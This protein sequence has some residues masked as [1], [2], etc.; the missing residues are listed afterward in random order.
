MLPPIRLI[1]FLSE[2]G[3]TTKWSLLG[4]LFL[5]Y[6]GT[7]PA[8]TEKLVDTRE[9]VFCEAIGLKRFHASGIRP[10]GV[11]TAELVA[12]LEGGNETGS[13]GLGLFDFGVDLDLEEMGGW[14]GA[15]MHFGAFAIFGDDPTEDL[16]GDF[17][18][19]S[20]IAAFNTVRLF[21]AW[22][23][24][25]WRDGAIAI[26]F[27]QIALDDDF[28]VS[29][30][31]SLF[32]NSAFGVLPTESGNTG[33]PIF[34]LG[35]PGIWGKVSTT[36][37]GYFQF[38]V[39]SGDAGDEEINDDGLE[40][41][42]GGDRGYVIFL[43]GGAEVEIH[44]LPGV[45]KFGGFYHTA[46]FEDLGT[47]LTV[48]GNSSL[49]FSADQTLFTESDPDQGLGSFFRIGYS[50]G[51]ERNTVRFHSDFGLTYSGI[52]P[53]RDS[54]ILGIA[55]SVT[56]FG[57]DFLASVANA[58]GP[59]AKTERILEVTYQIPITPCIT[60]QP[61]LQVIF[62]PLEGESDAVVVGLRVEA[63]F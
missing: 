63:A 51:E 9:T 14:S 8:G 45:Y 57:A 22:L 31:A 15:D 54:D 59:S 36:D 2:A 7:C 21:Q 56:R 44:G 32:L 61:D 11:L 30:G 35:A 16:V 12:N 42:L 60:L 50:L 62:D 24:Q 53:G 25:E 26:R 37:S 13:V 46:D 43:E 29:E 38:G 33:A 17:N 3:I 5:A 48:D 52:F 47:G 18:V 23:Q 39:Y 19:L 34:P 49:Y 1:N 4:I 55:F 27:G 58:S 41:G 20:N 6:P 40:F 10:Y 28:M